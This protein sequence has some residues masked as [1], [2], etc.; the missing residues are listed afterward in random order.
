L[1]FSDNT[2][3]FNVLNYADGN[4][5]DTILS[6]PYLFFQ[7]ID[8]SNGKTPV[9]TLYSATL[10]PSFDLSRLTRT[11]T[12]NSMPAKLCCADHQ[13]Q[14]SI[15]QLDLP[16]RP[17]V[18]QGHPELLFTSHPD[19]ISIQYNTAQPPIATLQLSTIT[20]PQN[21]NHTRHSFSPLSLTAH[22]K[23]IARN[24]HSPRVETPP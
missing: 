9:N 14:K 23:L 11:C 24:T 16:Q 15:S 2:K 12:R 22:P 1:V 13:G 8:R 6:I 18:D 19:S 5:K 17:V 20:P 4:G 21:N 7:Y 3:R 10:R